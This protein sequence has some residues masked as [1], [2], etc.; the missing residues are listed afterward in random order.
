VIIDEQ[1]RFQEALLDPATGRLLAK[2]GSW[3]LGAIVGDRAFVYRPGVAGRAWLGEVDLGSPQPGVRTT[4]H[5]P[6][7]AQRCDFGERWAVCLTGVADQPP[8]AVP[9][10]PLP[11]PPAA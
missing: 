4:L 11:T 10:P 2:L 8:F 1:R 7:P 3:R 5:L 9:L 6:V